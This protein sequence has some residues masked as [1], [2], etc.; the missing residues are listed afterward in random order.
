[1]IMEKPDYIDNEQLYKK[2]SKL[3]KDVI[4]LYKKLQIL[5]KD[6]YLTP[7]QE[8]IESNIKFAKEHG[9]NCRYN[10]KR[11]NIIDHIISYGSWEF[12]EKK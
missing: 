11:I 4:H 9:Y 2:L 8:A 12:S 7:T 10:S 3:E 1:M 6:R 5:E